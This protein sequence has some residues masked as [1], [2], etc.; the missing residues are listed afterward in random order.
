MTEA[1]LDE[2]EAGV[3]FKLPPEYRRVAVASPFRPIGRDSVYW[4]FDDPSRVIQETL[5]PLADAGYD[6]A[7]WRPG[8]LTIGE[9]GAGDL[10]VMDSAAEGL[11]VH[12]LSHESHRLEPEYA[13]FS[14]F[15]EEWVQAPRRI[16]TACAAERAAEQAEWNGRMRRTLRFCLLA[17]P[18]SL[19]FAAL[20]SAIVRWFKG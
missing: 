16:E 15:V 2:M 19:V 6:M 13:T 11:P 8:L 12:C 20:V 5:A 7:D 17:I 10:Y 1:Q 3:G 14:A 9:S 18:V 4:F